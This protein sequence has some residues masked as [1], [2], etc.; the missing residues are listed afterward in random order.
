MIARRGRALLKFQQLHPPRRWGRWWTQA[1]SR[2]LKRLPLLGFK[3]WSAAKLVYWFKSVLNIKFSW[4]TSPSKRWCWMMITT[5]DLLADHMVEFVLERSDDWI[6]TTTMAKWCLSERPLKMVLRRNPMWPFATAARRRMR[7]TLASAQWPR[8]IALPSA[9]RRTVRVRM[10]LKG[11]LISWVMEASA[12]MKNLFLG[13]KPCGEAVVAST[14]LRQR[15]ESS[16][17]LCC[18]PQWRCE[19]ESKSSCLAYPRR[20]SV[21]LWPMLQIFWFEMIFLCYNVCSK[22]SSWSCFLK[23]R[24]GGFMS[25]IMAV[26]WFRLGGRRVSGHGGWTTLWTVRRHG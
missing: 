23:K 25:R 26:G 5:S 2:R 20:L 24:P 8:P 19:L 17:S 3:K 9:P 7:R 12:L 18:V 16:L 21:R 4:S 13:Q 10:D 6:V 15:P 22:S 14:F 1:T 11:P